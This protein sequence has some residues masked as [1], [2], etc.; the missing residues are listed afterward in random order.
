[1]RLHSLTL[2][3]YRRF[4]EVTLEFPD[5]VTALVGRNGAG[6]STVVEAIGWALFGND[7]A[8][9]DKEYLKRREAPPTDDL[10]VTLAFEH[11]GHRYEV[12]RRL[13][14]AKQTHTAVLKVDGVA[15]VAPGAHSQREVTEYLER[16]LHLD[17]TTFFASLVARQS[18]VAGLAALTPADRKLAILRM[19]RIDVVD[20]AVRLAR[21]AKRDA[22][23]EAEMLAVGPDPKALGAAEAE[24]GRRAAVAREAAAAALAGAEAAA[25]AALAARADVETLAKVAAEHAAASGRLAAARATMA[26]ARRDLAQRDADL[27]RFATAAAELAALG[28]LPDLAALRHAL[29]ALEAA[30]ATVEV[31]ARAER[32]VAAAEARV[33]NVEA[34]LPETDVL[35]AEAAGIQTTL[36]RVRADLDAAQHLLVAANAGSA[37]GD[38]QRAKADLEGA[39]RRIVDVGRLGADGPCP[40]CER[41]LG[42]H[43]AHLVAKYTAEAAA[44][45]ALVRT[46]EKARS[47]ARKDAIAATER[48]Q[49][50]TAQA[51]ELE[52]RGRRAFQA[53]ARRAELVQ[54]LLAEQE[55]VREAKARLASIEVVAWSPDAEREAAMRVGDAERVH[56]R[57]AALAAE[58]ARRPL[59]EA[60]RAASADAV[61]AGERGV[62]EAE[63]AL[64]ALAYDPARALAAQ[65]ALEAAMKAEGDKR[66]AAERAKAEAER[67][68]ADA[69][70]L[71][72]DRKRALERVERR[73][74][75]LREVS[76]LERLAGDRETGLLPDFKVHLTGRIRPLLAEEASALYAEATEGRYGELQIDD[77]YALKVVDDGEAFPLARMS[78][79]EADLAYLCLRL[80]VG[81]VL[82]E[83]TGT[84]ELGFLVLDEVFGSQ[85]DTRR[86]AILRLLAALSGRFR[87]ILLVTHVDG[88]KEG[89]DSVLRVAETPAGDALITSAT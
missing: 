23:R 52:A 55:R 71:A 19:L 36:A 35:A 30:R 25:A 16:S 89:V 79:G 70:R 59:V 80:A 1:M 7:A 66:V 43:H 62:A 37:V 54:R 24:A 50:L 67:H 39:R 3:N 40:T 13:A 22:A 26:A 84:G 77:D 81:R 82:A 53:E 63:A 38:L 72:E 58:L 42:D 5:G 57:A 15:A 27:A 33:K 69:L 44:Q 14:G 45:E 86:A 9:T 18:D 74:A 73:S 32:E 4:R 88:V 28:P 46:L 2:Q 47:Q 64:A 21:Q 65:R 48:V 61:A 29:A 10:R 51:A 68:A 20:E 34:A 85:D 6:K 60:D 11:A 8:R 17:A 41:T 87:Q 75:L 56:A 12:E 83:R 49:A 78:G 76:T 31:R